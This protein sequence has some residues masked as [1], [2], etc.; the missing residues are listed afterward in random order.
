[1]P[2]GT[3]ISMEMPTSLRLGPVPAVLCNSFQAAAHVL[4]CGAQDSVELP[5]SLRAGMFHAVLCMGLQAAIQCARWC[6]FTADAAASH[7]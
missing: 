5:S 3:L 6:A 2:D 1:M 7:V 4:A